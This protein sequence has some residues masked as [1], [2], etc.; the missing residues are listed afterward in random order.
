[1]YRSTWLLF[2]AM[3]VV[4]GAVFGQ[5]LAPQPFPIHW[6]AVAGAGAYLAEVT[7][8]E[9]Q[10]VATEQVPA[11]K[12]SVTMSLVPGPYQLRLTTLNRFLKAESDTGWVAFHV[13]APTAPV[14][15]A[16]PL[17][18]SPGTEGTLV[19]DVSGLAR[20]AT[21]ALRSPTGKG[22]PATL[23][24]PNQGKVTVT[25]P[26][27]QER[28]DWTILVTNPPKLTATVGRVL[29]VHY[30]LP[31]LEKW[32]D[33]REAPDE[34]QSLTLTGTKFSPE[35]VAVLRSGTSS[36]ALEIVQRTASSLT[37]S[38]P[39]GPL[40]GE[41]HLLVANAPDETTVD[42]GVLT[43]TPHAPVIS[44]LS[45]PVPDAE[46]P[47]TLKVSGRHFG[48]KSRVELVSDAGTWPATSWTSAATTG[49]AVFPPL[50]SGEYR[51]QI[52]EAEKTTSVP[53]QLKLPIPTLGTISPLPSDPEAENAELSISISRWTQG[54][55]AFLVTGETREPL[56]VIEQGPQRVVV[57]YPADLDGGDYDLVLA[58]RDGGEAI[59][60]KVLQIP[61]VPEESRPLKSRTVTWSLSAF[62]GK[63]NRLA[64]VAV[65]GDGSVYVTDS[66]SNIVYS[67]DR[68][69]LT[70]FAGSSKA[71]NSNGTGKSASF[72]HPTG[73]AVDDDGNVYVADTGNRLVR[74]ITASGK[75]TTFAQLPALK[76]SSDVPQ[77]IAVAGDGTVYVS[78]PSVNQI[79]SI[80]ADGKS[81]ATWGAR[82]GGQLDGSLRFASFLQPQG[83]TVDPS[84][85]VYVADFGNNCLRKITPDGLVST[86]AGSGLPGGNDGSASEAQFDGPFGVAILEGNLLVTELRGHRVRLVTPDG[87][88]TTAAGT[89]KE[90]S[91]DGKGSH[92]TFEDLR[93]VAASNDR[94]LFLTDSRQAVL[95]RIQLPPTPDVTSSDEIQ[96]SSVAGSGFAL[97][98]EGKAALASFSSPGQGAYDSLGNFYVADTKNDRIRKLN[99]NGIVTTFLG[100]GNNGVSAPLGLA[101]D[102]Y[103][104]VYVADTGHFQIKKITPQGKV[105]VFAGTGKPGHDDGPKAS[106]DEPGVLAFDLFG[107]LYVADGP[108]VRGISPQGIVST[109]ALAGFSEL[110]TIGG[111]ALDGRRN[112][113]V[114]DS[115]HH[116]VI[117]RS[118]DGSI[119]V[120]AGQ[121][122]PGRA[123]GKGTR[124]QFSHP[125]G[126]AFDPTGVL[127]VADTGNNLVRT[128]TP[129]GTVTT[130]AGSGTEGARNGGASQASFRRPVSVSVNAH[131]VLTVVD[132]GNHQLREVSLP[133]VARAEPGVVGAVA[134][135]G[136]TL[137]FPTGLLVQANGDIWNTDL[138]SLVRV[139][140]DGS[141]TRVAGTEKAGFADGTGNR[142]LFNRPSSLVPL[143][144]TLLVADTG[145]NALRQV[146]SQGAVTTYV[147]GL[148]RPQGLAVRSDGAV[149]VADTGSRTIRK[150]TLKGQKAEA[151]VWVGSGKQAATDG[152]GTAASFVDP[153]A[154]AFDDRGYL[155][156]ADGNR[157]REVSP[158]GQVTTLAGTGRAGN[159]NGPGSTAEF[160]SP[161]ALVSDASG[162]LLVADQ[163][164]GLLR[165]V[166]PSG[167]TS[168]VASGFR[169]LSGLAI[170]AQSRLWMTDSLGRSLKVLTFPDSPPL[171]LPWDSSPSAPEKGSRL[172]RRTISMDGRIEQWAGVAP[173]LNSPTYSKWP[174]IPGSTPTALYLAQDDRFLY[175]MFVFSDGA[176]RTGDSLHFGIGIDIGP[177][178]GIWAEISGWEMRF[179]PWL[180]KYNAKGPLWNDPPPTDC[181][182]GNGF[183]E[184]RFPIGSFKQLLEPGK[185]YFVHAGVNRNGPSIRYDEG[186]NIGPGT[187]ITFF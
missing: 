167:E 1:M 136:S 77:G 14:V 150:V 71:G 135:T 50:P 161:V 160:S 108:R 97:F 31:R 35:A 107:S 8:P 42:A 112:L 162:D 156:V 18:L 57:A 61:V 170:D 166:S 69:E 187:W 91:R 38:L 146:D 65:G 185:A 103:D 100:P 22:V 172:P 46:I 28:G 66:A 184:V 181:F 178:E 60:P 134:L 29:S 177:N 10:L 63:F 121:E 90:G 20:D 40:P 152:L 131:K 120:F 43:L 41:Y 25:I 75:T 34:P 9:G 139:G 126:L 138:N 59:R 158:E 5:D 130:L 143:G 83:L 93:G 122:V 32:S 19:L 95:R 87:T 141:V 155:F 98:K 17:A 113:Y 52:T 157:I 76:S 89:G 149:F 114:S 73:V 124:A 137:T 80:S 3:L 105:S 154:L 39:V 82:D 117:R 12:T 51:L 186:P 67:V 78:D 53:V 94:S 159:R 128:I 153:R 140:R 62:Q 148:S 44:S 101:V 169:R 11:G 48:P 70:P 115:D 72:S 49:A 16:N 2:V 110:K 13:A 68:E 144:A 102:A 183:A 132:G 45:P 23:S 176:T 56:E 123:D 85:I 55:T 147:K 104:N 109:I 47:L 96:V 79:Y 168:L 116:R 165:R 119:A 7:D 81:V 171:S 182:V 58:N 6:K 125:Q 21:A 15:K 99:T 133:G 180:T 164:S 84:G 145:N 106:F 151:V 142:A 27:L 37:V 174:N 127:Y 4:G 54:L 175:A 92:S 33:T 30:P 86:L 26:P 163:G 88:V 36:K 118:W 129:E 24:T 173:V 74:K 179:Q 64:D 111:L